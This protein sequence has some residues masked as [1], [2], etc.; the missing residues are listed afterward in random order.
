MTIA[1]NAKKRTTHEEEGDVSDE[2]APLLFPASDD[3]DYFVERLSC[4][5]SCPLTDLSEV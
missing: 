5:Y 1:I 4:T 2:D 3:H